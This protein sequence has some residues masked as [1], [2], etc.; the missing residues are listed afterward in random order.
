MK[1]II[2]NLGLLDKVLILIVIIEILLLFKF[3]WIIG[4][5][6]SM[7]PTLSNPSFAICMKTNNYKVGDIVSYKIDGFPIVHRIVGIEEQ[8]LDNGHV[9]RLFTLKG[10]NNSTEDRF[11]IYK[12]NILCK[13]LFVK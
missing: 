2:K 7:L 4:S 9:V 5:G 11:K 6:D 10:D 12:E 13:L 1:D 8:M 3:R